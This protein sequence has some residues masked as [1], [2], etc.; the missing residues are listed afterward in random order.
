MKNLHFGDSIPDRTW[1]PWMNSPQEILISR[2]H[3][4][5]WSAALDQPAEVL[6]DLAVTLSPDEQERAARFRFDVHRNRFIAGRGIL[7]QILSQCLRIPAER[8]EFRF[9]R[10]GKPELSEQTAE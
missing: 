10:H 8:V 6:Q 4:H 7:R 1:D 5:L 9:T 3:V 2:E